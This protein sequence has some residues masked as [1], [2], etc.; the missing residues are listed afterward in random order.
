[1]AIEPDPYNFVPLCRELEKLTS[2][3]GR[4]T[5]QSLSEQEL[6]SYPLL[7]NWSFGFLP[8]PCL[9]GA[10]YQHPALGGRANIHTS[11][12]VLIDPARRWARTWYRFYRLG[13]QRLIEG[14]DA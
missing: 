11:E 12:L 10:V 4:L 13:K 6:R 7:D 5:A 9:V 14:G 1:M 2:D 8:T 3:L